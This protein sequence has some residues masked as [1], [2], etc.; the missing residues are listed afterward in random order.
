MPARL[1]MHNLTHVFS[2]IQVTKKKKN[3]STFE[4]NR[5]K[6]WVTEKASRLIFG[7]SDTP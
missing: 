4:Y 3:S 5:V 6:I 1:Q 2:F 7:W